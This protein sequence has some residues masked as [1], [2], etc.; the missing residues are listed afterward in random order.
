MVCHRSSAYYIIGQAV[1]V[2]LDLPGGKSNQRI[3][4]S[5]MKKPPR[6]E[7]HKEEHEGFFVQQ[8]SKLL[9]CFDCFRRIPESC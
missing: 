4:H 9:L 7:E 6:H 8:A 1:A 5:E 2:K 3:G